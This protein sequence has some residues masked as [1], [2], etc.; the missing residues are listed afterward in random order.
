MN[1]NHLNFMNQIAHVVVVPEHASMNYLYLLLEAQPRGLSEFRDTHEYLTSE[2]FLT[3]QTAW[4]SKEIYHPTLLQALLKYWGAQL[5]HASISEIYEQCV[6]YR[7]ACRWDEKLILH[8]GVMSY[9]LMGFDD[10]RAFI[11]VLRH[12]FDYLENPANET[13]QGSGREITA[14][15]LNE[16]FGTNFIGQ[17]FPLLNFPETGEPCYCVGHKG[18]LLHTQVLWIWDC[19]CETYG[20]K[21]ESFSHENN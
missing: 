17:V 16:L 12:T 6:E 5:S 11:H 13:W 2:E 1:K 10:V 21:K 19:Y 20:I 3:Q 15:M 4:S 14:H 7:N 8:F 18:T 9:E